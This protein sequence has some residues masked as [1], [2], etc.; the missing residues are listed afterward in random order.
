MSENY[1]KE[2]LKIK[3]L[4]KNHKKAVVAVAIGLILGI[5]G[6]S[7]LDRGFEGGNEGFRGS[8]MNREFDGGGFG[9]GDD[10]AVFNPQTAFINLLIVSGSAAVAGLGVFAFIHLKKKPV[11]PLPVLYNPRKDGEG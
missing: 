11:E 3:R 7:L 5:S 1:G 6:I 8:E 9:H 4:I 10:Q 2:I